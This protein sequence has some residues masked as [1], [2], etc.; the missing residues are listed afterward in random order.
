MSDLQPGMFV[1]HPEHGNGLVVEGFGESI[2]VLHADPGG[3]A[4]EFQLDGWEPLELD[5]VRAKAWELG[6]GRGR[7]VE[8][9]LTIDTRNP[10]RT[11]DRGE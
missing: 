11:E 7:A 1:T 6:F 8:R 3:F 4:Q 5:E 2:T 10:Y 9:G